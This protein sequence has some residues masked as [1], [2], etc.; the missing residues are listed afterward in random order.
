MKKVHVMII[1][2]CMGMPL[3]GESVVYV[4]QSSQVQRESKI[5]TFWRNHKGKIR[6]G[7]GCFVGSCVAIRL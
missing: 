4:A 7:L 5:K 6:L 2:V 3:V 1:F